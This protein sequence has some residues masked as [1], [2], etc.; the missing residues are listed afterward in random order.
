MSDGTIIDA[1][2]N[3]VGKAA[4]FGGVPYTNNYEYQM[5]M[6]AKKKDE[7]L[8]RSEDLTRAPYGKLATEYFKLDPADKTVNAQTKRYALFLKLIRE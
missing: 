3:I 5:R 2:G 6:D 4:S 7:L 8:V 1:A